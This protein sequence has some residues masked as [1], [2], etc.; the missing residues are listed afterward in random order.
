MICLLLLYDKKFKIVEQQF[1]QILF[2]YLE[3]QTL[4]TAATVDM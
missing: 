4:F 2:L 3:K 1:I